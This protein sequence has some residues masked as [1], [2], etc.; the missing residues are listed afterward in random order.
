LKSSK[1]I[2][3]WQSVALTVL[4]IVIGAIL[5]YSKMGVWFWELEPVKSF[6]STTGIIVAVIVAIMSVGIILYFFMGIRHPRIFT[7]EEISLPP[8]DA[9]GVPPEKKQ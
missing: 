4:T 1:G 2:I 9:P 6:F 3:D 7:G 5:M 8:E